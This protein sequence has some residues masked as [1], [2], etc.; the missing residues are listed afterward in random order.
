MQV[1]N[2]SS[3]LYG[4]ADDYTNYEDFASVAGNAKANA[5]RVMIGHPEVVANTASA[6]A[7]VAAIEALGMQPIIC[8]S[9]GWLLRQRLYDGCGSLAER[10]LRDLQRAQ[11]SG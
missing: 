10:H 7:A 2:Q 8:I 4:L 9:S 5:A 6:N 3:M 11:P 1:R